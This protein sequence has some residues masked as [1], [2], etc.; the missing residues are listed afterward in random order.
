METLTPV[1]A[2]SSFVKQ[3]QSLKKVP[4]TLHFAV[5]NHYS[6]PEKLSVDH[7]ETESHRVHDPQP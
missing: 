5:C 3:L 6:Y 4:L 2:T 1:W 7:D